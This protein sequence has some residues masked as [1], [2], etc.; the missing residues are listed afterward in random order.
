MCFSLALQ[1]LHFKRFMSEY[2]PPPPHF[3]E[4]LKTLYDEPPPTAFDKIEL[5]EVHTELI[6]K[7]SEFLGTSQFL[8]TTAKYWITYINLIQ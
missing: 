8:G 5:S 1:M 6:Q 3:I 2:G 7:Y 4:Q